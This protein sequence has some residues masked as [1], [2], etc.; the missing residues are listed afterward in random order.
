[1]SCRPLNKLAPRTAH[2]PARHT[3]VPYTVDGAASVHREEAERKLF[4]FTLFSD[5]GGAGLPIML[6]PET[7][8]LRVGSAEA[9]FSMSE[10]PAD[11]DLEL[12]AY[13]HVLR[14]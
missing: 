13:S 3:R 14:L 9:P 4:G 6:R 11:E 5:G 7:G 12:R 1:M 10:L 8:G 2:R